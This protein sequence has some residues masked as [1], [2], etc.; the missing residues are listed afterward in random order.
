MKSLACIRHT[1]RDVIGDRPDEDVQAI[2]GVATFI[3]IVTM[4]MVGI[5]A[6]MWSVHQPHS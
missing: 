2:Y 6:A 3:L 4:M 5:M 1:A